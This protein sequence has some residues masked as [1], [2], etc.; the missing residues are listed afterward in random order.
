[1]GATR[2]LRNTVNVVLED[3]PSGE[4]YVIT[5]DGAVGLHA[6]CEQNMLPCSPLVNGAFYI[7]KKAIDSEL[8]EALDYNRV[9]ICN[10][11]KA[12]ARSNELTP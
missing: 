3:S 6:A 11:V 2:I 4:I 5:G 10:A 9:Y 7:E 12:D 8:E 1:M